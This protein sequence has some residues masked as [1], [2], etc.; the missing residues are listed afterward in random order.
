MR[1]K[2]LKAIEKLIAELDK[3]GA[4]S[5][6]TLDAAKRAVERERRILKKRSRQK[7][8]NLSGGKKW[9]DAERD[10]WQT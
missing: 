7:F 2:D 4:V 9:T 10:K 8:V 5:D 1:F 6:A 3:T